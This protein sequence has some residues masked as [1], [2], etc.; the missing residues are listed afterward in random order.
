MCSVVTPAGIVARLVGHIGPA[1]PG[2]VV[3]S[4]ADMETEPLCQPHA[5]LNIKALQQ[6]C[7]GSVAVC[8]LIAVPR[9]RCLDRLHSLSMQSDGTGAM[10]HRHVVHEGLDAASQRLGKC[11]VQVTQ[12]ELQAARVVSWR[13]RGCGEGRQPCM[14]PSTASQ[15]GKSGQAMADCNWPQA[16]CLDHYGCRCLNG[17]TLTSSWP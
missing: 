4:I 1:A 11:P 17:Q 7:S 3:I 15:P 13:R 10:T 12:V 14:P 8:V 2:P 16:I 9:W 5:Q 6:Q